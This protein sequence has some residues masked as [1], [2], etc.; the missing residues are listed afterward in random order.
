MSDPG[1]PTGTAGR[2]EASEP[3]P[4]EITLMKNPDLVA[5]GRRGSEARWGPRRE[6]VVRLDNLPSGVHRAVLLLVQAAQEVADA[7]RRE[8][9]ERSS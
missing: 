4:R 8:A 5:R 6:A 1:T 7:A 2:D 9:S 3:Q